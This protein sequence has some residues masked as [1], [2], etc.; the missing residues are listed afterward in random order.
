MGTA[1][2]VGTAIVAGDFD[3]DPADDLAIGG[4]GIF[5]DVSTIGDQEGGMLVLLADGDEPGDNKTLF[6][7]D[8]ELSVDVKAGDRV[9]AVLAA[10]DLDDDSIDELV[11]GVPNREVSGVNNAGPCSSSRPHRAGRMVP[12]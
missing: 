11:L 8:D 3:S 4:P 6:Y 7:S 5:S 2:E 12:T 10:G 9:G 1:L